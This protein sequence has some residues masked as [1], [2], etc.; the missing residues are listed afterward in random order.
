MARWTVL[1]LLLCAVVGYFYFSK[2]APEAWLAATGGGV[3]L[4]QNPDA[5]LKTAVRCLVIEG[6]EKCLIVRDLDNGAFRAFQVVRRGTIKLADYRTD[7]DGFQCSD[8]LGGPTTESIV[9]DGKTLASA[10]DKAGSLS[11][12][13][14]TREYLRLNVPEGPALYFDCGAVAEA[15][16]NGSIATAGSS[17][18]TPTM[19]DA[20]V[21]KAPSPSSPLP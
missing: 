13:H 5:E 6:D 18:V 16:R 4:Y 2:P 11:K 9:K 12:S 10:S 3:V 8:L 20:P 19:L 21:R 15:F 7:L 14:S 17:T 1:I